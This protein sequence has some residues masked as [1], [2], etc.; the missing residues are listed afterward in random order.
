MA[1]LQ[2][3]HAV[4]IASAPDSTPGDDAMLQPRAGLAHCATQRFGRL[5]S[6]LVVAE[7][8]RRLALGL[9]ADRRQGSSLPVEALDR[10]FAS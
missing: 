7:R 1:E 2:H 4:N 10:G 6:P 8:Q 5:L 3:G 9:D